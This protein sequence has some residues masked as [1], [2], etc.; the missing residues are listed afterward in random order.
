VVLLVFSVVLPGLHGGS[1]GGTVAPRAKNDSPL[2]KPWKT[3]QISW[4]KECSPDQANDPLRRVHFHVIKDDSSADSRPAREC[5]AGHRADFLYKLISLS[6]NSQEQECK[7][8]TTLGAASASIRQA[9]AI[10]SGQ[11][12]MRHS[13]PQRPPDKAPTSRAH[14]L[15][16]DAD[17]AKFARLLPY[18]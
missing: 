8:E 13:S 3:G 5:T 4:E 16:S 15:V 6:I 2:P 11:S 7:V 12:K 9:R 10:Q 17:H 18:A 14:V 1:T